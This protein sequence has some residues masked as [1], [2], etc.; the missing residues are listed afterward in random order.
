MTNMLFITVKNQGS[1]STFE[2]DHNGGVEYIIFLKI[3]I[4]LFLNFIKISI[5]LFIKIPYVLIF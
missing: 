2:K 4:Y 5:V 1:I 3:N